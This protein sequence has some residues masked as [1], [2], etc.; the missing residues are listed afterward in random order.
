MLTNFELGFWNLFISFKAS[1]TFLIYS[2]VWVDVT[3]S[4][5]FDLIYILSALQKRSLTL[6]RFDQSIS[7][8]FIWKWLE[9]TPTLL[10]F[11]P[12]V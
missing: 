11:P 5:V 6:E 9:S 2:R 12:I 3:E 10:P 1:T 8:D 7:A 4:H